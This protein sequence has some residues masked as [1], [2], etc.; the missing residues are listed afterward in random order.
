MTDCFNCGTKMSPTDKFCKKCG[1]KRKIEKPSCNS[2]GYEYARGDKFCKKCGAR[3]EDYDAYMA[4]FEITKDD[5]PK[6][7]KDNPG[8]YDPLITDK[9]K[10]QKNTSEKEER[11]EKN[12]EPKSKKANNNKEIKENQ[13]KEEIGSRSQEGKSSNKDK[14]SKVSNKKSIPG[15]LKSK[16]KEEVPKEED[17]SQTTLLPNINDYLNSNSLKDRAILSEEKKRLIEESK[18]MG[19]SLNHE[20][21]EPPSEGLGQDLSE[22]QE[23]R[24]GDEL[25]QA[26]ERKVIKKSNKKTQ[27]S[28]G[29]GEEKVIK[30]EN[31]EKKKKIKSKT[32]SDNKDEFSKKLIAFLSVVALILATLAF[33]SS[34]ADQDAVISRFE[35]A[36]ADGNKERLANIVISDGAATEP[37]NM[38]PFIRLM[39]QDSIYYSGLVSALKEDASMLTLS[40]DYKS[41]RPYRLESVGSKY[42]F[43]EDYRVALDPYQLSISAEL[44]ETYVFEN[45]EITGPLEGKSL[46]PGYYL[47]TQE[48][49]GLEINLSPSNPEVVGQAI[50]VSLSG[51]APVE[52]VIEEETEVN[53]EQTEVTETEEVTESILGDVSLK[54]E[55]S[56]ENA[57]VH[58]NRESTD[59]S[60]A[61]FN[62]LAGVNIKEGDE[63]SIGFLFPWGQ[64]LSEIVQYSGQSSIALEVPLA[65]PQTRQTIMEKVVLMLTEDGRARR[66]S[67]SS[68]YT[69]VI[70]PEL[71]YVNNLIA[72][73]EAAGQVNHRVYKEVNFD[74]D[75][76]EIYPSDADT[77]R[78]FIGGRVTYDEGFFGQ[79]Q[80]ISEANLGANEDLYGFHLTYLPEEGNWFIHTWGWTD[81]YIGTDVTIDYNIS[82]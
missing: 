41:G 82:Q 47:I 80:E 13:E 14:D 72:E 17:L 79:G 53:S 25:R 59:M 51:M 22:T 31:Q 71:S 70:E 64:G 8:N 46:I 40:S 36:L 62:A 65:N 2:C 12:L 67:D 48:N 34:R 33:L 16:A 45:E 76:F 78:A 11:L 68:V 7:Y 57:I 63:I 26:G 19:D 29:I 37:D 60:V 5:E 81:R 39:N 35:K 4:R 21:P 20:I 66:S 32:T 27:P 50:T 42:I 54:I 38:D 23:I 44:D 77:Y 6:E 10:K 74:P 3:V 61:D 28:K 52:E 49:Q 30:E 58:I 75:S 18:L 24:L 43:F 73:Q 1:S 9:E 69:S 55:S 15:F 56:Q